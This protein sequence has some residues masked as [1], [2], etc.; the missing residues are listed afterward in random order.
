MLRIS[1]RA[2]AD[3]PSGAMSLHVGDDRDTWPAK[4]AIAFV[5]HCHA[6]RSSHGHVAR[7]IPPSCIQAPRQCRAYRGDIGGRKLSCDPMHRE[8][9]RGIADILMRTGDLPD[10]HAP[11]S[12][13]AGVTARHPGP[14]GQ[15]V[16]VRGRIETQV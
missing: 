12:G 15:V 3:P 4:S 16:V 5:L 7:P 13:C 11:A 10:G 9:S 6:G 1:K 2:R 14:A 8:R